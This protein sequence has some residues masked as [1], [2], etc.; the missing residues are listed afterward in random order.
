MVDILL[1]D[2]FEE[3]EGL[4]PCDILRRAEIDV[5]LVRAGGANLAVTGSHGI[6]LA[7]E[8]TLEQRLLEE[9]LPQMVIL[10]GGMPG[11]LQLEQNKQVQAYLDRCKANNI[12]VAAICAAPS[13]LGHRGELE[14]VKAT[15]FPGYEKELKGALVQEAAVVEDGRFI[16]AKG[17]GASVAFSLAIVSKLKNA[18]RAELI[19]RSLQC[20]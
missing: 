8:T 3:I 6:T 1:A 12:P 16:T 7:C 17:M 20:P 5:Q 11:T 15:C 10:P 4:T 13:I 9:A 19:G 2:G 14:G 18:K